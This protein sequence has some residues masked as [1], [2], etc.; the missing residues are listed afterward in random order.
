MHEHWINKRKR[1]RGMSSPFLDDV[2]D[3]A[4]ANGALGGKLVGAG[5]GGFLMFY[6]Q[7]KKAL[8]EEMRKFDLKEM[9]IK[10]DFCGVQPI[11][12]Q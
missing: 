9:K 6:S 1:T 11:I 2:Y 7:D 5:G 3:A 10:F 8:R 12:N 4:M